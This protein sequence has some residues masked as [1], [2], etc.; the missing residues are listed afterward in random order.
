MSEQAKHTPGPWEIT[1][2]ETLPIHVGVKD[3]RWKHVP[4]TLLA[5]VGGNLSVGTGDFQEDLANARLIAAAPDMAEAADAYDNLIKRAQEILTLHLTP[6]GD[7]ADSA[8]SAL[9]DLL[10][11]PPWREANAK[12][13]AARA[14][15]IGTAP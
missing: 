4:G 10:D 14:K 12:F 9:L 1:K 5:E 15:A 2:G 7:D 11:G 3:G 13:R 8:C 6:D